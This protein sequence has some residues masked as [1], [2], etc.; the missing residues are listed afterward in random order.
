MTHER[1]VSFVFGCLV[2][3]ATYPRGLGVGGGLEILWWW[4]DRLRCHGGSKQWQWWLD[5]VG[6]TAAEF[7]GGNSIAMPVV[8]ATYAVRKHS[9]KRLSRKTGKKGSFR[10]WGF[11]NT[12][13]CGNLSENHFSANA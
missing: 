9:R 13:L 5:F 2:V 1:L 4:W 3:D 7:D 11:I 8:D 10:A 6:D 12:W